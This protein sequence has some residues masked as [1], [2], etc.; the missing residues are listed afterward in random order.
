MVARLNE[1]TCL[2]KPDAFATVFVAVFDPENRRFRYARAGHP[3]ALLVDRAGST[4]ILGEAL[5]PPLG[6]PGATYE[7]AEHDFPAQASLVTYT[8]GLIERRDEPID[9]RLADLVAAAA[10]A[11]GAE[12]DELCDRLVFELLAGKNLTDDAALLVVTNHD[13]G[14]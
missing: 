6:L 7:P 13:Q 3:P 5:G 9:S 11:A 2:F 8:D 12:P 4:Q 10:A 14:G 1:Y